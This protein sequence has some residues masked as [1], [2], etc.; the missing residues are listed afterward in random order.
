MDNQVIIRAVDIHKTYDTGR[1]KVNALR[2]VNLEIQRSEMVAI[3]GPS[4]SGKST[5]MHILGALDVPTAGEYLL[6]NENVGKISDDELSKRL[7]KWK[8]KA[9]KVRSGILTLYARLA[10]SCAEGAGLSLKI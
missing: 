7:A 6:D 8:P 5:L 2:G 9:P 3:M 4:G 10:N 1:V